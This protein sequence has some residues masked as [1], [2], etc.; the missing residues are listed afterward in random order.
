MENIPPDWD[1]VTAR[2]NC[3][4]RQFFERLNM[5]AQVNISKRMELYPPETARTS[6][7]HT[8][9]GQ[10][11]SVFSDGW[12]TPAVRFNLDGQ[13]IIIESNAG[14]LH[15]EGVVSLGDDGRCRLKIGNEELDEWQVLKRSLEHLFFG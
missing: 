5:G 15:L 4:A 7:R 14:D 13:R 10:S 1:W 12:N 9:H 2:Y 3:S 11:F 6:F 8:A